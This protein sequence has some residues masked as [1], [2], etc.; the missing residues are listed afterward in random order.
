MAQQAPSGSSF[1][2]KTPQLAHSRVSKQAKPGRT[3]S[4]RALVSGTGRAATR[5]GGPRGDQG[6]WRAVWHENGQ[7][8]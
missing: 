2:A 4:G 8:Q 6:R 1:P 3:A 7:R 5:G